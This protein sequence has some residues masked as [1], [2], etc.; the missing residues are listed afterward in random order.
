MQI[1]KVAVILAGVLA[2]ASAVAVL[3]STLGFPTL[4]SGAALATVSNQTIS[5]VVFVDVANEELRITEPM[6]DNEF[7]NQV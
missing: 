1:I 4:Y 3:D 2:I 7:S 6:Y 5:M